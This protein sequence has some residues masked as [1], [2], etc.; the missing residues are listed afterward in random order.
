MRSP[1]RARSTRI[2][3]S[4]GLVAALLIPA[5]APTA[6]ADPVVLRVGVTQPL[7]SVNPYGTALVVGVE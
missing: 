2:L 6:A 4:A 7:D 1:L 5:A 3:A